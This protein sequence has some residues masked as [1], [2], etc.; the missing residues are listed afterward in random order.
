MK[1]GSHKK[2]QRVRKIQNG[3]CK[4]KNISG[5]QRE[6]GHGVVHHVQWEHHQSYL[7]HPYQNASIQGRQIQCRKNQMQIYKEYL[8]HPLGLTLSAPGLVLILHLL[9]TLFIWYSRITNVKRD[10]KSERCI[11]K[12]CHGRCIRSNFK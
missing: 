7:V 5:G 9:R 12:N 1:E 8:N 2:T 11:D 10:Y 4:A 3:K 6:V